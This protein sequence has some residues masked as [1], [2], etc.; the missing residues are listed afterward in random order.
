MKPGAAGIPGLGSGST[1]LA[2]GGPLRRPIGAVGRSCGG[3]IG[4]RQRRSQ[5]TG[6]GPRSEIAWRRPAPPA[7]PAGRAIT[8][9][10]Y[11]VGRRRRRRS[12]VGPSRFGGGGIRCGRRVVGRQEAGAGVTARCD[13]GGSLTRRTAPPAP[14][15]AVR[16]GAERRRTLWG[17]LA[18][19]GHR[20]GVGGWGGGRSRADPVERRIVG[21]GRHRGRFLGRHFR[22]RELI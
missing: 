22:V 10:I 21:S 16:L 15:T 14:P 6:Y 4:H 1:R 9:R 20:S 11:C 18:C 7:P 5:T 13:R 2:F 12:A 19:G 3:G 17:G 8:G